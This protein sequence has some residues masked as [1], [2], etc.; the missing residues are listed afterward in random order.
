MPVCAFFVLCMPVRVCVCVCV[1]ACAC[2]REAEISA[3]LLSDTF[4]NMSFLL[5][6]VL[7]V[8]VRH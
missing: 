3:W 1:C 8:D 4:L 7:V 2:V 6:F 5:A